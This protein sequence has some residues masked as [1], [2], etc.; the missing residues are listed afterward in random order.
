MKTL[1]FSGSPAAPA[2]LLF[3]AFSLR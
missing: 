1:S 3:P 2:A